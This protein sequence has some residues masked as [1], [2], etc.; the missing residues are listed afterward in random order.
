[1]SLI[2]DLLKARKRAKE[3][4]YETDV[5]STEIEDDDCRRPRKRKPVILSS[6]ESD[7]ENARNTIAL[8]KPRPVIEY[9]KPEQEK[10]LNENNS[11]LTGRIYK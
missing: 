9:L 8:P 1:M 7:D 10:L 6:S 4:E 11:F 5:A 3:A 2:D